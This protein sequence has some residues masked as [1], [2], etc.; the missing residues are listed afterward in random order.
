M[1]IQ[2]GAIPY[3]RDPSGIQFLLVTSQKGNWIFPKGIVEPGEDPVATAVKE[4]EEEAGIRGA[5]VPPPIGTYAHSKWRRECQVVMFLLRYEE[6]VYPWEEGSIRERRWC[7]FDDA[8]DRLKKPELQRLLATAR[9][10]IEDR[11]HA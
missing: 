4:C 1:L 11:T 3:R 2:A 8:F 5:V 9:K 10:M 6:D 7:S